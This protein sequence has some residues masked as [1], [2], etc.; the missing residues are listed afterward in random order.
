MPLRRIAPAILDE[1]SECVLKIGPLLD[2][3]F[4]QLNGGFEEW[5]ETE[6]PIRART[7]ERVRAMW[8][9]HAEGKGDDIEAW[10]A[11]WSLD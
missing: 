1:L 8:L 7:A 5:V 2:E 6:L 10:K 4:G 3:A 11:L 9:V